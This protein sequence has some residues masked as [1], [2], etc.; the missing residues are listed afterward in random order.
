MYIFCDSVLLCL[1]KQIVEDRDLGVQLEVQ[2]ECETL[3][4]LRRDDSVLDPIQVP[5]VQQ[6]ECVPN[7]DIRPLVRV[8]F[9]DMI[10]DTFRVEESTNMSTKSGLVIEFKCGL[11][12]IN[13][14]EN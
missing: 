4:S 9:E 13:L 6:Y 12:Y 10:A 1:S 7:L 11:D 8:S 14:K 3:I 2:L 5:K